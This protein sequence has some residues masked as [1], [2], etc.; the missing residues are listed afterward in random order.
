MS[1]FVGVLV[2]SVIFR[3]DALVP[4]AKFQ[5]QGVG[6]T[7]IRKD[8]KSC[9]KQL[10][11]TISLLMMQNNNVDVDV[12]SSSHSQ[13]QPQ[14]I[15]SRSGFLAVTAATVL[16][17]TLS[18]STP[19][20]ASCQTATSTTDI[21]N[22]KTERVLDLPSSSLLSSTSSE[23]RQDSK[24]RE[25]TISGFVAGAALSA[26]KTVVKYPLD[27]ATV[28]LQMTNSQYS[29]YDLGTLFRGSFR[30][31]TTPL[32]SN[33]PGGAVF[34]AVKDATKEFLKSSSGTAYLPRWAS[35][36]LAVLAASFPYWAVRNPSEV[37]KTRQQAGIEGY[38]EGI[39]ALEA[40]RKVREKRTDN[41]SVTNTNW[42]EDIGKFYVGYGEN[43]LYAF[44]ADVIKFVAYENLSG[45][46]KDISPV[47]GA[48][49]GAGATAIAQFLTTPLDV[50]RNRAM[51]RQGEDQERPSYIETLTTLAEEEGLSGLFAG[52][53]PRVG[54]AVLS[55]AIQFATYEETKQAIGSFFQRR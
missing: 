46:R 38:G 50:V 28:R 19:G 54:K 15:M 30:G 13:E 29:I 21:K 27:T 47:E 20:H 43:I 24:T 1:Y 26:T 33:I 11:P 4:P 34:F 14:R 44:P 8:G 51:A 22:F 2:L 18:T 39:S 36:S 53:S 48:V 52:V 3:A 10:S 12:T 16:S 49:Y 6:T 42:I 31:I 41:G 55:G 5:W 45:G 40:F 25:E 7:S 9:S 35:T 23:K 37:V 32:L 17:A